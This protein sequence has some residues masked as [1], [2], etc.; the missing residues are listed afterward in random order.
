MC[1]TK[2]VT[3]KTIKWTNVWKGSVEKFKTFNGSTRFM[4]I[5]LTYI[6]MHVYY[7]YASYVQVLIHLKNTCVQHV[8]NTKW[9]PHD[10]VQSVA[11]VTYS[12]KQSGRT[13][14]LCRS[15]R[16]VSLVGRNQFRLVLQL[17]HVFVHLIWCRVSWHIC[18]VNL[19]SLPNYENPTHTLW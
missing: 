3:R 13:L 11:P 4:C 1:T 9:H 12:S 6:S 15:W 18:K 8:M 5:Q 2:V 14:A 10:S 17:L 16:V 7:T 19:S